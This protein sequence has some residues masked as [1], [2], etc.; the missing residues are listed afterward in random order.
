MIEDIDRLRESAPLRELLTQYA[1]AETDGWQDRIAQLST[2]TGSEMTR[3][4]G[5]LLACDWIEQNTGVVV[6]GKQGIVAG[7]YRATA[8]GRAILRDLEAEVLE[9]AGERVEQ[10]AA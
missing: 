9:G 5:E 6:P 2:V 7:C 4:H 10:H 8:A 1:A 3:L